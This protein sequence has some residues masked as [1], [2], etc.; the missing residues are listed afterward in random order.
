MNSLR[1]GLVTLIGLVF[2]NASLFGAHLHRCYDG[3]EPPR[4]LHVYDGQ[5]D[6]HHANSGEQH[7]D[8]DIKL[9]DQA[10]AKVFKLDHQPSAA[11][12]PSWQS[13]AVALVEAFSQS[14]EIT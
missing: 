11:T 12:P 13:P 4:S 14:A 7:R 2:L 6:V 10:L 5:D 3:N 1:Q 9:A 8:V